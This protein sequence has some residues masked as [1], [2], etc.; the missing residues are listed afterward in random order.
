[1]LK[2]RFSRVGR[3]NKAKYR[4][5]VQ[6]HTYAPTGKHVEILGSWD[7]HIKEGVFKNDRVQHWIDNGAQVSDSVFNLFIS[8]G[9]IKGEKRKMNIS[10]GKKKEGAE[11]EGKTEE[12]K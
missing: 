7:P 1:M 2:I 10:S 11:V 8:Q 12:K 9:V 4:I 6:E 3:R 5:V